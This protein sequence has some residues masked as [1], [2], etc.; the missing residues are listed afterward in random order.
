MDLEGFFVRPKRM[1]RIINVQLFLVIMFLILK[2]LELLI[3]I[4]M[5]T[6]FLLKKNLLRLKVIITS[7]FP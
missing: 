3:L 1:L 4:R 6:L 5:D 2:D 7:H